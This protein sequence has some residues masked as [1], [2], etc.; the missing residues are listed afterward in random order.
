MATPAASSSKM[1]TTFHPVKPWSI[2]MVAELQPI[3]TPCSINK[4][5]I[6]AAG[7]RRAFSVWTQFTV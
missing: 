6:N 4:P 2:T 1:P 7:A 3:R 5:M